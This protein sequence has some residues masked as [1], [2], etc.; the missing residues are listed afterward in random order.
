MAWIRLQ[1]EKN[2][3]VNKQG[4]TTATMSSWDERKKNTEENNNKNDNIVQ[5][6]NVALLANVTIA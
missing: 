5:L 2:A 1:N 6:L 4:N 3:K